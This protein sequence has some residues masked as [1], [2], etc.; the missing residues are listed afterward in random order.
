MWVY[1]YYNAGCRYMVN[2]TTSLDW[3]AVDR[4]VSENWRPGNTRK[5]VLAGGRRLQFHKVY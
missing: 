5:L 3:V 4:V 2:I 1:C